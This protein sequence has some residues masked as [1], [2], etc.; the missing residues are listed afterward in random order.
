MVS[1][2]RKRRYGGLPREWRFNYTELWDKGDRRQEWVI[3]CEYGN[4]LIGSVGWWL[5]V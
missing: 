2:R 3:K 4:E 1:L 5:K